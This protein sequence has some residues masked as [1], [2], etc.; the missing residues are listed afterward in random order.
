MGSLEQEWRLAQ[1]Y[2]L[3][4]VPTYQVLLRWQQ[5]STNAQGKP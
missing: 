3:I 5:N 4:T 2:A 1:F